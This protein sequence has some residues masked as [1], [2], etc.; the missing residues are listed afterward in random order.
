MLV[1]GI[2]AASSLSPANLLG[3]SD[4]QR[5]SSSGDAIAALVA[6]ARTKDTNAL[7]A[8]FGTEGGKLISPDVVQAADELE[9]F[10]KRVSE[11]VDLATQSDLRSILQLGSDGWP[12][13]IPLVR[14][15]DRWF[16]DTKEGAGEILNRRI[17]QNE[18]QTLQVCRAYVDAQREYASSDRDGDGVLEYAQKLRSTEGKQDG[19]YWSYRENKERSPFGPLISESRAEGYRGNAK[20]MT[21]APAPYHGYYFKIL[22]KQGRS[23]LGGKYNYLVNGNMIGGFALVAWPAEW[24]NT[25][26]M[27]FIVNQQGRIYQRNLGPGT[28]VTAA[29][30]S[31]YD[32]DP[33]WQLLKDD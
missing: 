15:K 29:R 28:S 22:T 25:G 26:I 31:S 30:M 4:E 32:P 17:G 11:K 14:E 1:T 3:A 7:Q 9:M 24:G 13:P 6:A 10:V 18:I 33:K 8:I 20:I 23:A 12:F 2:L 27:T 21:D 16:F 5:F 19:L